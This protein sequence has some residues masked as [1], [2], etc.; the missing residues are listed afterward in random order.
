MTVAS[1]G[2]SA[3]TRYEVE[4][5]YEPGPVSLVRC[6]LETGRTHQIRVHLLAIG[7]PVVGDDVYGDGRADPPA[8]SG[9]GR[10]FLHAAR[11]GFAHPVRGDHLAFEAPLPAELE[12][13]LAGLDPMT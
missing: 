9:L 11:L 12:G 5:A 1:D 10:L 6:H 4:Q 13:V 8:A 3:R 7:H 2:R